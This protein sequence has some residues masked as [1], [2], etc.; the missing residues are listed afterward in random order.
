[1]AWIQGCPLP[2][3]VGLGYRA[4]AAEGRTPR[5]L[6]LSRGQLQER[7]GEGVRLDPRGQG[8]APGGSQKGAL[9]CRSRW[10]LVLL[11]PFPCWRPRSPPGGSPDSGLRRLVSLCAPQMRKGLHGGTAG[12]LA[13]GALRSH[14]QIGG[15][16]SPGSVWRRSAGGGKAPG[17]GVATEGGL[18][19]PWRR[20][21]WLCWGRAPAPG[22]VRWCSPR[23]TGT[24]VSRVVETRACMSQ[25]GRFAQRGREEPGC[26]ATSV[27]GPC[28]G[29]AA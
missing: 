17:K 10:A 7:P 12:S 25:E 27:L 18:P 1:M 4:G 22:G 26:R 20:G 21:C 6:A 15:R 23:A 28:L 8:R 13:A 14:A 16:R 24:R 9:V 29:R 3:G 5:R 19:A 11:H 2:P